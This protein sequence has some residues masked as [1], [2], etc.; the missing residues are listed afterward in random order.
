MQSN[1]IVTAVV[2]IYLLVMLLIGYLSSKKIESNTDFVVAGRRLGPFL[3]AGTLAATEIGGG[4]SLGV[5]QQGME[6]HGLSAAWYIITMGFAFVIL[7]FLAPKFR[8]AM[9][10]TV[11]EYFRRRYGKPSGII[12]SL[13]LNYKTAVLIVGVVVTIYAIMGGLWSVTLTDFVQVFLIVI[14]MIIALP[15]G[16]NLAGGWDNVV[17]NVPAET[18]DCRTGSGIQ[19][20]RCKRRKSSKTGICPCCNCKLYLRFCS[21]TYGNHRTRTD[22]HGQIQCCGLP[23]CWC[24]LCTSGSCYGSNA[25]NYLRIVICRYRICHN[26]KC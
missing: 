24:P 3:M 14:G 7:T 4:S 15:F 6:S 26:V 23:G 12:T 20:L 18:F 9:V 5:V 17:A 11:P 21:D 22:Q 25:G 19:I 2:V 10:K 16:M 13:N 1:I 8:A